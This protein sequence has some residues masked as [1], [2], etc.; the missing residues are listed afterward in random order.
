MNVTEYIKKRV[1][2]QESWLGKKSALNKKYFHLSKITILVS[3]ALI[4]LL[5][6]FIKQ[7]PWLALVVAA[8]GLLIAVGSGIAELYKFQEKWINYRTAAESLKQEKHMYL[9]KC[10]AYDSVENDRAFRLFVVRVESILQNESKV[11]QQYIK[12]EGKEKDI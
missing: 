4:P 7:F 9:T 6:A 11:W 3:A 5:S 12:Q 10:G 1:E 8:L 2:D